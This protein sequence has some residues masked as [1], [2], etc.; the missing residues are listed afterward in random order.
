[1]ILSPMKW[2]HLANCWESETSLGAKDE[3]RLGTPITRKQVSFVR[4]SPPYAHLAEPDHCP[5]HPSRATSGRH[6]SPTK[7]RMEM[8]LATVVFCLVGKPF[9]LVV[10]SV[11]ALYRCGSRSSLEVGQNL[12]GI[13][14]SSV[15]YVRHPDWINARIV[16]PYQAWADLRRQSYLTCLLCIT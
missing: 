11:S 8:A 13:L 16:R 2:L 15:G 5:A 10:I 3:W 12:P 9:S 6:C 1:M 14:C 7:T 4:G